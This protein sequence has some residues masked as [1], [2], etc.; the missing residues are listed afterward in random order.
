MFKSSSA[1]TA[2][3]PRVALGAAALAAPLIVFVAPRV[4]EA[5]CTERWHGNDMAYVVDLHTTVL[6]GLR[7]AH[8]SAVIARGARPAPC[9]S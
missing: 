2:S 5:H 1:A 4:A 6:A 7:D 8:V 9:S 3:L